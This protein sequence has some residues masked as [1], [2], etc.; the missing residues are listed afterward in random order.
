MKNGMV[1]II[2]LHKNNL[3]TGWSTQEGVRW[4]FYFTFLNKYH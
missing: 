1:I 4:W 3:C 2:Y